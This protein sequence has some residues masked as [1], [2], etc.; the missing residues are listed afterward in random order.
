MTGLSLGLGLGLTARGA[1]VF[2]PSD[3]PN[4]EAWYDSVIGLES[5]DW[6]D[7]S[8][9]ARNLDSGGTPTATT[10]NGVAALDWDG[11]DTLTHAAV[12][13]VPTDFTVFF[14]MESSDTS[15]IVYN[16]GNPNFSLVHTSGSSSTALSQGL[17]GATYY[18]ENVLQSI[19]NRGDAFTVYADGSPH[20]VMHKGYDLSG[21]TD[22]SISGYVGLKY[23]G[24]TGDF[25]VVSDASAADELN[26]Y[27]FLSDKFSI[28]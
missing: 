21:M 22:F 3:L 1:G 15:F 12:N 11:A 24:K 9:H 7:Q 23:T 16:D 28:T 25:I 18:K 2:S 14:V 19:S 6:N 10:I 4:L 17:G 13:F 8:S 27:N 26:V 20:I 5:G